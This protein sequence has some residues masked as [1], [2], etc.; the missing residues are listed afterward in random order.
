[1]EEDCGEWIN[2][3]ISGGRLSRVV[4]IYHDNWW[5]KIGVC[6]GQRS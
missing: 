3:V 4:E 1:V 5:R 2:I 6:G